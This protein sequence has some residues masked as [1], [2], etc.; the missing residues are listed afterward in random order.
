MKLIIQI[1]CLNEEK[2]L[3]QTV[4][5]LPKVL[6]RID[7]IEVLVIDDGSEDGTSEVARSLEVDHLVRLPRNRGLARAFMAGLDASLASG[8]DLIVNTDADNQYRGEDI[9]T[10]IRP[11]LEGEA[12]IVIG[13]RRPQTLEHFSFTKR[14]LQK[15]GSWVV[16]LFS[17]TDVPDTT[18]GFRAY[19]RDAALRIHVISDYTYTLESIIQAGK[20]QIAISSEPV[21]TNEPLRRST[22]IKSVPD[23]IKKS[24]VAILRSYA[25]YEPLRVFVLLGSFFLLGGGILGIRFLYYYFSSQGAA[26]HV[27]SVILAGVL[28]VIGFMIW[29]LGILAD[30]ISANRALV[31]ETLY[32]VKRMEL[33]ASSRSDIRRSNEEK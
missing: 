2:N 6:D 15:F 18:S 23:Y 19:S 32:R 17:D 13:D 14:Q 24:V 16:R 8:A 11:I 27:Q 30:L 10:L 1:P 31:E 9:A 28:L 5:D 12:E 29:V 7:E 3:R 21:S 26:G 33:A 4:A 25:M 20:K 22:L